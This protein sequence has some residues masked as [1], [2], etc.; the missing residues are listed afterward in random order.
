MPHETWRT[1]IGSRVGLASA[2]LLSAACA[3]A[4]PA[5]DPP[6]S[7][8]SRG[9]GSWSRAVQVVP[10]GLRFGWESEKDPVAVFQDLNC[11][12][13]DWKRKKVWQGSYTVLGVIS[14]AM[15][16]YTGNETGITKVDARETVIHVVDYDSHSVRRPNRIA[17]YRV[18]GG[19]RKPK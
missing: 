10:I 12:G 15:Y 6:L 17:A 8:I 13:V 2:L 9:C 14:D 18:A 19:S 16:F 11:V 7:P 1:R 5:P 3:V 4:P